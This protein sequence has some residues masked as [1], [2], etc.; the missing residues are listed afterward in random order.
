[1]LPE[2]LS[3]K[4]VYRVSGFERPYPLT[5][6]AKRDVNGIIDKKLE[7]C[8]KPVVVDGYVCLIDA[9]D[10]VKMNDNVKYTLVERST[11]LS[12]VV[13]NVKKKI[14]KIKND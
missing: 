1:M 11:P 7:N 6:C 2:E 10:Y 9:Y 8:V 4:A 5:H 13:S 14:K 12:K 3:S